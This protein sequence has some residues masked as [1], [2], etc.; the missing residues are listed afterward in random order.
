[1][2]DQQKSIVFFMVSFML[3]TLYMIYGPI[4]RMFFG[5]FGYSIF[6]LCLM[7]VCIS[8]SE[9]ENSAACIRDDKE[10]NF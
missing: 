6:L 5:I 2:N 1:M 4:L 7:S 9:I 3:I 10:M 8:N